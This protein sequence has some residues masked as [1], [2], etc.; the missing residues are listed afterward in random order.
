MKIS[1][2]KFLREYNLFKERITYVKLKDIIKSQGFIIKEFRD[3]SELT[4]ETLRDYAAHYNCFAFIGSDK[5][6]VFINAALSERDKLVLLLHEEG[7]IYNEHFTGITGVIH[8]TNTQFEKTANDFCTATLKYSGKLSSLA[9]YIM[10]GAFVCSVS[11]LTLMRPDTN[12]SNTIIVKNI[13]NETQAPAHSEE[14]TQ[15]VYYT[16]GGEVYHLSK[17]CRYLSNSKEILQG[18]IR[19]SGKKRCCEGCLKKYN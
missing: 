3:A 18:T 16:S 1:T 12:I 10:V 5:K 2:I 19:E 7:H 4:D 8:L 15:T 14:Y 11:A 13:E 6:M 9:F 17:E